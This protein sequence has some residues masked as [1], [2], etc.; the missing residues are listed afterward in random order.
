MKKS[1]I[2]IT[3]FT[4]KE[5]GEKLQEETALLSRLKMNHA[6]SPID[7]PMKIRKSRRMIARI[8]TELRKRQ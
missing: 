3:E 1:E 8:I 6:V 2:R 5:L 7:N 4:S